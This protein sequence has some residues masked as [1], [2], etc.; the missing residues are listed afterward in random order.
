MALRATVYLSLL[1]PAGLREVAESCT[2]K[3]HYAS[4]RLTSV[5]GIELAFRQPFF[6]EFTLRCRGGAAKV[7]ERARRAGFDLGPSA[8]GPSASGVSAPEDCVLVAVTE[9]RTKAEID[10]LAEAL[11]G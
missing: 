1:G 8:A 7:I 2:R 6:K 4:E 9:R 11:K 10:A 3:A 5:P